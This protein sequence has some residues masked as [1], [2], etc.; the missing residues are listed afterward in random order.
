MNLK[1]SNTICAMLNFLKIQGHTK[2]KQ[3]K[4]YYYLG[5]PDMHQFI[6]K[7]ICLTQFFT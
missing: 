4:D 3:Q 7:E 2:I 6:L 1:E 5:D